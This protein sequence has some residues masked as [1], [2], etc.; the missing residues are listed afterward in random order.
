M[1]I[2]IVEL[3]VCLIASGLAMGCAGSSGSSLSKVD[4]SFLGGIASYDKNGDDVVTCDEW[5][6]AADRLFGRADKSGAGVLTEAEYRELG[7]IDGTFAVT[8]FTYF[9]ANK[10]GKIDKKEF[11]ERPNPAFNLADKDK[12][13]KLNEAELL[14][15]R[16]ASSKPPAPKKPS[17]TPSAIPG[18]GGGGS[19]G[20]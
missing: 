5:R 2:P 6:A 9:D 8:S 19:S 12:D 3:G 16:T 4:Q 17:S 15:A 13:C 20:Y 7:R 10:D 18:G 1:R 14:A 11:V